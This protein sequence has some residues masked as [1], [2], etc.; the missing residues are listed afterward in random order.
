[1]SVLTS[2]IVGA[3]IGW[4]GRMLAVGSGG[5]NMLVSVATGAA[6]A[7]LATQLV[8]SMLGFALGGQERF[9]LTAV[10]VAVVGAVGLWSIVDFMRRAFVR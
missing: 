1:M 7:L 5:L 10:V 3:L 2:L 4:L 8:A 9:S 6:G